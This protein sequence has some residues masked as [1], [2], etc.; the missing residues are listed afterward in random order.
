MARMATY[1]GKYVNGVAEIHSEILKKD[2]LKEW[3]ELYPDKFQNKTNGITQ[4]R[5]LASCNPELT[6]LLTRL[7]GDDSFL[8]DLD[9]LKNIERYAD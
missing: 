6:E 2:T 4:R 5:W 7:V 9:K 8:K 1:I 3:Y